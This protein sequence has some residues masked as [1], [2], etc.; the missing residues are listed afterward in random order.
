MKDK[1]KEI[2]QSN[3][4]YGYVPPGESDLKEGYVGETN[5]RWGRRTEEHARWDKKSSVYKY[6][7]KKN[8]EVIH[9]DFRIL[10]RGYPKYFNRRIAEALYV[11]D[12]NPILN[13]HKQSYKLKLFN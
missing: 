11:K 10:E 13:I 5:V 4:I 6:G 2:H 7:Q 9:G 12:H 1:V 8:I 3:L